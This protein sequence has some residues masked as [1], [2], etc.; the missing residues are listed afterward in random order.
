MAGFIGGN[1]LLGGLV[2]GR[3]KYIEAGI[4]FTE[5]WHNTYIRDTPRIGPEVFGWR[6]AGC[7]LP[8]TKF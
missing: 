4:K 5:A 6:S 2:L 8:R 1:F 7:D 3:D